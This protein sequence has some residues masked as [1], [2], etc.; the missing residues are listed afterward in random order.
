MNLARRFS[1][2]VRLI[3]LC[4]FI[5]LIPLWTLGGISFHAAKSSIENQ[6]T[7]MEQAGNESVNAVI[8]HVFIPQSSNIEFLSKELKS[9]EFQSP[10]IAERL[11][12]FQ[13]SHP[14]LLNT[15]VG[16]E[17][18]VYINAPRSKM[19]AGY[20]PRKRPWYKLAM[21]HKGEVVITN[22][23]QAASVNAVVVTV[24]KTLEDGTG[25]VGIDLNLNEF[26]DQVKNIKIGDTGYTFVLDKQGNVVV[27]PKLK[28]AE[29]AV[30]QHYQQM[31]ANDSGDVV[32]LDEDREVH[33]YYVTN[34]TTGWKV[35]SL[36][37]TAEA[38]DGA[39]P[40]FYASVWTIVISAVLCT[41]I[42]IV[43]LRSVSGPLRQLKDVAEKVQNGDLTSRVEVSGKDELS[44]LGHSVNHMIESLS[45]VICHIT[46]KSHLIA[47]SSE[48]LTASAEQSSSATEHVASMTQEMSEET[49]LQSQSLE[50]VATAVEEM[51]R[52]IQQIASNSQA[53]SSTSM[54]TLESTEQGNRALSVVTQ[55]MSTISITVDDLAKIISRLNERSLEINQIVGAIT[56]ISNQTNLLSLNAAIEAARAGEHGKGFAVVAHEVRQLA[57][58]SS[59]SAEEIKNLIQT[60]QSEMEL[61]VRQM[62]NSKHAVS[63]GLQS[64]DEADGSFQNIL[65]SMNSVSSQIQEVSAS[66]QQISAGIEGIQG[67]TEQSMQMQKRNLER[68]MSISA[69][70][71]EQLAS[72]EEI[73]ASSSALSSIADSLQEYVDRFKL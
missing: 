27:H 65:Q 37:A 51:T 50:R 48:Q 47:S 45:K 46:E 22:P 36:L 63:N 72:T 66:V 7:R 49:L 12:R 56:D 52:G 14:E 26:F 4:L 16:N 42:L 40:I 11:N 5:M 19:P 33:A 31:M 18:G 61:A 38:E 59:Q 8:N 6:I 54:I 23:Y 13:S 69:S 17:D 71:E 24:A 34:K 64:V 15:F 1:V 2:K 20:D 73:H 62:N 70:A 53:V 44:E 29:K 43:I 35:V 68:V 10:E 9:S 55:N 21:E 30:G 41:L 28:S 32:Y 58:Q 25:V 3:V 67:I 60:I 39:S 57:E